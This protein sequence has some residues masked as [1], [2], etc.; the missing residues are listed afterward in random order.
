[1]VVVMASSKS[2]P[3]NAN[4]IMPGS[5]SLNTILLPPK[6][7]I[8]VGAKSH[9]FQPPK[10]SSASSSL[11]T[12]A[13]LPPQHVNPSTSR[14]RSR[15]TSFSSDQA[16]PCKAQSLASPSDTSHSPSVPES[17]TFLSPMPFA[18]TQYR[19]A[20]GLDTPTAR[21][22]TDEDGECRMSPDLHV[23]G[24]GGFQSAPDSYFPQTI[25][26]LSRESNGRP[27]QHESPRIQDGLGK[28]V[29]GMVSAAGK[30]WD[31]CRTTAFKVG[32]L[33]SHFLSVW[34]QELNHKAYC[35][36]NRGLLL[37]K[38][39]SQPRFLAQRKITDSE[40][41]I[42]ILFWRRSGV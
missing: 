33:P 10:T 2:T 35:G 6:L 8:N 12:T 39:V 18:N 38:H 40:C 16:T 11:H 31:F 32:T 36:G 22:T 24:Y 4:A 25:S 15:Y 41:Y 7:D 17:S 37:M 28:A 19:L 20:G 42:G 29:C 3:V 30:V 13:S 1:M 5:F 9:F 14:K 27:R 21:L 26:A 34:G 23:R